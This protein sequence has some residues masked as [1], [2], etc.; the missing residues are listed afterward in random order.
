MQQVGHMLKPWKKPPEQNYTPTLKRKVIKNP[1]TQAWG[2][3]K[4][5]KP[6]DWLELGK[7]KQL[8]CHKNGLQINKYRSNS[9]WKSCQLTEGEFAREQ[10]R[11]CDSLTWGSHAV[12]FLFNGTSHCNSGP[13]AQQ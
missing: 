13:K 11:Y 6:G 9:F 12:H 5:I 8:W 1:Q 3:A 4:L 10:A 7:N 2:Q